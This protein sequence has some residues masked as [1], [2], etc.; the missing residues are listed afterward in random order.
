MPKRG[1][2]T[3]RRCIESNSGKLSTL[4]LLT[5]LLALT[6]KVASAQMI[7]EFPPPTLAAGITDIATGP[8]GALWF[9]EGGVS[10]IGRI[11]T[12]GSFTEFPIPT[13]LISS[14]GLAPTAIAA[15]PDGA[16]WFTG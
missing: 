1:R 6:V 11:T 14:L 3:M 13:A 12:S 2:K 10:K 4:V 5:V 16:L 9:T 7:Q 15:G 8:D